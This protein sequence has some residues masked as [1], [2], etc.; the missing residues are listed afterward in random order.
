MPDGASLTIVAL[1]SIPL[2][3]P[4]DD[5]VAICLAALDRNDLQPADGDVLVVSSK[6]VAKAED[7]YVALADVMPGEQAI[8][9]AETTGKDPRFVQLVLDESDHISRQREGVLVVRHRHGF[10]SANAGIDQSNVGR[11]GMV[12]LMPRDPDESARQLAVGL[13]TALGKDVGI[14]ISDTHGRPFRL[15]NVGV[16]VGLYGVP[17]L[18]DL[19]GRTDLFGRELR[20]SIQGYADMI[21]SAAHLVCGEADEATPIVLV[22]GLEYPFRESRASELVRPLDQD[23]YV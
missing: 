23:L 8:S 13:G 22:R 2:V 15:G 11:D 20:V 17:G 4:G 5:L 3:F 19:R 6:I 12:L 14:V 16:A 1:R 7:R 18:L 21:A 9:I 10:T